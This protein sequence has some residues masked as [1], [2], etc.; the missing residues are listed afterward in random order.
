MGITK[1]NEYVYLLDSAMTHAILYGKR[2]FLS[3]IL[4]KVNVH[5]IS[6]PVKIIDGP[7]NATIVLLNGTTLH[8]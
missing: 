6:G 2:F 3:M 8:I 5:T 7:R 4:C 1:K